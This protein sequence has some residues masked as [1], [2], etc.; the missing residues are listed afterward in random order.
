MTSP[1][2][3]LLCRTGDTSPPS[4]SLVVKLRLVPASPESEYWRTWRSPSG[5]VIL[6]LTYWPGSAGVMG[7]SSAG[8]RVNVIEPVPAGVLAAT[9]HGLHILPLAWAA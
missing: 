9:R 6:T 7:V 4:S 2:L 8:S 5:R 3:T 1:T